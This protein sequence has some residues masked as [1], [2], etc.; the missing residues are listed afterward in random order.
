MKTT[1]ARL[2]EHG[3]PLEVT[4]VDLPAL[5]AD[6]HGLVQAAL[7][8]I[9]ISGAM[10]AYGLLLAAFGV[11]RW[12]DAV[13]AVRQTVPSDLRGQGARGNGRRETEDTAGS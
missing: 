13:D 1:A 3:R 11:I 8:L 4:E 6:A 5:S 9:V 2:V 7:L 12:H 10:A